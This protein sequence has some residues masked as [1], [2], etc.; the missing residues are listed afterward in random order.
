MRQAGYRAIRRAVGGF[1]L[2]EILVASAVL[3]MIMVVLMYILNTTSSVTQRATEKIA[4]FQ[5]AR[6]AFS[7][8]N[9]VVGQATLNSYWDYD[10]PKQ[11][12]RYL[13]KSELHFL[14]GPAGTGTLPGTPGTG[15]AMAFQVPL[16]NT[17][18]QTSYGGLDHLLNACAFYINYAEEPSLPSPPFPAVNPPKYRYQLM[19]AVEPTENLEVY[20][21]PDGSAWLAG[22]AAWEA[23][24]AENVILLVAWPR[25]S[26][27]DDPKGDALTSNFSYN[28]RD[29]VNADPQPP[30]ANQLPPTVQVLMVAI[31]QKSAARY[32]TGSSPPAEIQNLSSGLFQTSNEET[33]LADVETLRG[34]LDATNINYRIFTSTIPIRESKMQ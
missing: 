30:S 6:R 11:P 16:G 33:F 21:E 26:P 29:Y 2:I 17:G 7:I 19:Q 18:N 15:Q 22:L 31:D 9:N 32:C 12:K 24:I 27:Q 13:R 3:A 4:A 10:D 20:N 5:S 28:S 34:R 23:P 14:I 25:Y 8:L 1:S